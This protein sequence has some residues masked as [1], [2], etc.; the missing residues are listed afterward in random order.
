MG[1][2]WDP[3]GDAERSKDNRARY[4]LTAAIVLAI[5]GFIAKH[6]YEAHLRSEREREMEVLRD[7]GYRG[8]SY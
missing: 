4:W 7:H 1:M 8:R 5:L 3:D 6:L 2:E